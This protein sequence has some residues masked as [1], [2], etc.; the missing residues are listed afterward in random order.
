MKIIT[1]KTENT[2]DPIGGIMKRSSRKK[3]LPAQETALFCGQIAL[4]LKS[5]ILLSDGLSVLYD[6]YKNSLYADKFKKL[7]EGVENNLPFYESLAAMEVF[8]EYMI[9]MVHIGE[10]TGK[11]DDVMESL[12]EYYSKQTAIRKAIKNAVLYPSILIAMMAV[13]ITV[14]VVKILPIFDQIYK[15]LG[16]ELYSSSSSLMNLGMTAGKVILIV[17][18][19][20]LIGIILVLILLGSKY[21]DSFIEKVSDWFSDIRR[22]RDKISAWRF[23]SVISMMFTSGYNMEEALE[24]APTVI[25][26]KNFSKKTKRCRELIEQ[27]FT[28][29]QAVTE[30]EIFETMQNKMI[31]IASATGQLDKVMEKIADIYQEEIDE[32]ISYLV[33]LTEPTLVAVL[34]V[35]IGG[36]LL[37]VMLPLISIISSMG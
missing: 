22:I 33:S 11:L 12:S 8:S 35:I 30:V 10:K 6:T 14:L 27:K 13:V 24:L 9:N 17:I 34:S 29:V 4:I 15:N 18:G 31:L 20:I 28:F 32:G 26:D 25:A 16:S 5:G 19:A 21:R 2:E 23:A 36:I 1:R 7:L 3:Q 37:T